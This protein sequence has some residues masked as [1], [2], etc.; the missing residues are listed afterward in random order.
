MGCSGRRRGGGPLRMI[1]A[2]A[3]ASLFC[4][5][6]V[7]GVGVA[8][9]L[10]DDVGSSD[11]SSVRR[12]PSSAG[13]GSDGGDG[14]VVGPDDAV[15]P[16][17][18]VADDGTVTED[19]SPD[20]GAP[21]DA[22]RDDTAPDD[23]ASD[24]A[25]PD[26][27]DAS[28]GP[29][30]GTDDG[31]GSTDAPDAATDDPSGD[32]AV[33]LASETKQPLT[34]CVTDT[35][36]GRRS[37][38]E[39]ERYAN[40]LR[41]S[42]PVD[43][44]VFD[45]HI[46][47]R[48]VSDP[49]GTT[50]NLFD[51]WLYDEDAA[52]AVSSVTGDRVQ[53]A[54]K[55]DSGEMLIDGYHERG[56]NAGHEMKFRSWQTGEKNINRY[57]GDVDALRAYDG[58][59]PMQRMVRRTLGADGFPGLWPE[60]E[61]TGWNV[62]GIAADPGTTG[63]EASESLSYLYDPGDD[64]NGKR[65]H[66]GVTGLFRLVDGY[67]SYDSRSNF[68]SYDE[69]ANAFRLYD[70]PGVSTG[71]K[72]D[73]GMFFPFNTAGEVF[74]SEN[75]RPV[76]NDD[77][78]LQLESS[79]ASTHE[80]MNHYFGLSMSSHFRQTRDGLAPGDGKNVTFS[81]SGDDDAWV[82]I[83]GVLIGDLGGIHNAVTVGIDF[84]TGD[85]QVD[86]QADATGTV[87]HVQRTT[88]RDLYRAAGRE[89]AAAWSATQPAT[90][91][92]GTCHT[93]RFFYL[94]R[95]NMDSNMSLKFN[96]IPVK[97][98]GVVKVDQSGGTLAGVEFDLYRARKEDDRYVHD[99]AADL[100]ATGRTD[101]NGRL[102]LE[103]ASGEGDEPIVFDDLYT[104]DP[105]PNHANSTYYVLEERAAPAGYRMPDGTI[106][107]QYHPS[108]S[109]GC[110]GYLTSLTDVTDG[111]RLSAAFAAA[112]ALVTAPNAIHPLA[113]DGT[114]RDTAWLAGQFDGRY[115]D[116]DI[117]KALDDGRGVM[118]AAVMA[119]TGA[120]MDGEADVPELA[121][122]GN[123]RVV[124]GNSASGWTSAP[125]G[126]VDAVIEAVRHDPMRFSLQS[127][128]SYAV[129]IDELPGD[130]GTYYNLLPDG[131]RHRT[132]FAVAYYYT[133]ADDLDR[134]SEAN[135]R[136]LHLGDGTTGDVFISQFAVNVYVPNISNELVVRKVDEGGD[137]I[138]R[139]G[140]SRTSATFSLYAADD[141]CVQAAAVTGGTP[142]HARL[143][144]CTAVDTATT[145]A[146]DRSSAGAATGTEPEG[147]ARFPSDGHVLAAGTY[148]LAETRPPDRYETSTDVT[149]IIVNDTGVYADAGDA[150]DDVTVLHGV[151][152]LL[153]TMTQFATDGLDRTLS[154]IS[155]QVMVGGDEPGETGGTGWQAD[156]GRYEPVQLTYGVT[157]GDGRP[158]PYRYGPLRESTAPMPPDAAATL[159]AV[160]EGWSA[161]SVSQLY[162]GTVTVDGHDIAVSPHLKRDLTDGTR[163]AVGALSDLVTGT[164]VVQIRDRATPTTA[165]AAIRKTIAG[166]AHEAVWN[167]GLA[168]RFEISPMADETDGTVGPLPA[169]GTEADGQPTDTCE[170]DTPPTGGRSGP[171]AIDD[172]GPASCIVTVGAP[173]D[174][175][176]NASGIGTFTFDWASIGDITPSDE[177]RARTY[178]YLIR[179]LAPGDAPTGSP[180]DTGG[181]VIRYSQASYRLD[182]TVSYRNGDGLNA[183]TQL[184]RLT[185]DAGNAVDEPVDAD[186]DGDYQG[187]HV[188][189]FTNT[190]GIAVSSLPFTGGGPAP[191]W[192]LAG[193][194]GAALAAAVIALIHD[195]RR[196]ATA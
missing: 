46:V 164:V 82:Y 186:T 146:S 130:L 119:Y 74:R 33:P 114:G 149:K 45:G 37:A 127:S 153:P 189:D 1:A 64:P 91:A 107:L 183:A 63:I 116:G 156:P 62:P 140:D 42:A 192:L 188:A 196:R 68:A 143:V 26:G 159:I 49:N 150:G 108:S 111:G 171:H 95:G 117:T 54:A 84:H 24:G 147:A 10:P 128:G 98:S 81:F 181:R 100:L 4:M 58:A 40:C 148:W 169:G 137:P 123:W 167:D 126:S 174:G 35:R 55:T 12:L 18:A 165:T 31:G 23:V 105:D 122:A 97:E 155:A 9:G 141:A 27:V 43:D 8:H 138:S 142:D 65:S 13:G 109:P 182:I 163:G 53:W 19:G 135:T 184:T 113:A 32:G 129:D 152:G 22:A 57:T 73:P 20:G 3:V 145:G 83:D 52:D 50:V 168:F 14:A 70:A 134:A 118:F 178:R 21:G 187:I 94:E 175:T 61:S 60:D 67:Y 11:P 66:G 41:P 121:D 36:D 194:A 39:Y 17:E 162:E 25:S 110:T 166:G 103:R 132:R 76:T 179:E 92:D 176:T 104:N 29:P 139:P 30:G 80:S 158:I 180:D 75:G 69:S 38:G 48:D 89:S 151:D 177:V 86:T 88:L 99:G 115:E 79:V 133:S 71:A 34:T 157:D 193:G 172:D 6:G 51:Y 131:D 47:T 160:D 124:T 78:T 170:R 2:V 190:Q 125:G 72:T 56:I 144:R 173:D 15:G 161:L 102:I 96:L 106:E 101:E 85:V 5:V 16:D 136:R 59:W 7:G 87:Q 195:H 44:D 93:L 120:R 154:D 77:G 191:V 112:S 28:D 90:F 185:D